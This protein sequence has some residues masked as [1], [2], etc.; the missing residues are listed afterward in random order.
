M[1]A[2]IAETRKPRVLLA[3]DDASA[4]GVLAKALRDLGLDV[5]EA[6]DG[7]RLLVAIGASYREGHDRDEFDLIVTDVQMPVASGIDIVKNLRRAGWKAPVII[8]TAWPTPKVQEA[9]ADYGAVLMQ[10]PIDLERFEETAL[11]LVQA[12][13]A[14]R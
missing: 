1:T 5:T 12:R 7:G 9:V 4:R 10:K 11:D 8:V 14:R 3:E 6:G 13:V 2:A